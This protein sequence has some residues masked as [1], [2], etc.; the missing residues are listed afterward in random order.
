MWAY[1]TSKSF[2]E[3][4]I[5][6]KTEINLPSEGITVLEVGLPEIKPDEVLIKV[7]SSA[8]NYNSVWSSLS[9]PVDP[10]KL[11]SGHI[12]RNPSALDHDLD[13]AI[14]GSDAVGVIEKAGSEV[15]QWKVGD[16][17]VVHCL[18]VNEN[19]PASQNDSITAESQSIWG[20]ETNFGA[21]AEFCKV[22][23]TQLLR[24][25]ENLTW[26]EASCISLTLSTAFRMLISKNGAQVKAG[27]T[28]LIWGAAG[29]LGSF[30]IQL[31]KLAGAKVVAVAAGE[32]KANICKSLGADV[33]IDR[34]KHDFG[35]FINKDGSPDYIKWHKARLLMKK[36]GVGPIDIVF[37]HVGRETL[38]LSLY[39]TRKGGK[40]VTCAASSGFLATIDLRY[41]WMDVKKLIG[42]HFANYLEADQAM[43]LVRKGL[44][45]PIVHSINPI[46]ALPEKMD[47]MYSGEI[48]GKVIFEH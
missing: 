20:Y 19:E 8:L 26:S 48:Y 13:Y 22:K 30:A 25:P 9:K 7:K 1:G 3:K 10:F 27:D 33:V 40:V 21:F 39:L 6:A 5:R 45:K 47:A 24:K 2:R 15:V 29:G 17:V 11:I 32:E 35:G 41:L 16:E 12:T 43:D 38:G 36:F 31:A 28:V 18:V 34:K 42:S 37:E 14:F 44:I 46:S 4:N 23:Q